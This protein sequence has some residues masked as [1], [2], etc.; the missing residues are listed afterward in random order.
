MENVKSPNSVFKKYK[1]F[2]IVDEPKKVVLLKR[3]KHCRD[4]MKQSE[5]IS[6]GMIRHCS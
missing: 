3:I 4:R 6:R 2:Q 1:E 5:D